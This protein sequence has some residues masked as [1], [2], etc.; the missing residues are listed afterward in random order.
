MT[1]YVG[2]SYFF[3]LLCVSYVDVCQSESVVLSLLV[4]MMGCGI[5]LY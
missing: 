4:L 5:C 3:G 2:K 1:T